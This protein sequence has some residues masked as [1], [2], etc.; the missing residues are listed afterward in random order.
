MNYYTARP[1]GDAKFILKD[2]NRRTLTN[3][4]GRLKGKVKDL[5]RPFCLGGGDNRYCHPVYEVITVKGIT[6]IIEHR[7]KG[8]VFYITD[9]PAVWKE[10]VGVQHQSP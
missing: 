10:L 9:E 1:S 6:E 4:N 5:H 7:E 2:K 3:A 8:D